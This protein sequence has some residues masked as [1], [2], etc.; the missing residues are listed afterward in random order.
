MELFKELNDIKQ[1]E[2]ISVLEVGAAPG[3]NFKYFNRPAVVLELAFLSVLDT[4][5]RKVAIFML[6]INLLF[7]ELCGILLQLFQRLH[8]DGVLQEGSMT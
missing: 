4:G 7:E 3:T 1:G 8:E 6:L 2:K 5:W